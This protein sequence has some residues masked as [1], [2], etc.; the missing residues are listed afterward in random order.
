[1]LRSPVKGLKILPFISSIHWTS[2]KHPHMASFQDHNFLGFYGGIPHPPF[3]DKPVS[4]S[5]FLNGK[6]MLTH[7]AVF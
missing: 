2:G 4:Y 5:I 6:F 7:Y 1:M 3:E